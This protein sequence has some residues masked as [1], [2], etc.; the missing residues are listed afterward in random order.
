MQIGAVAVCRVKRTP[1]AASPVQMRCLQIGPLVTAE[2]V[3]QIVTVDVDH[4]GVFRRVARHGA[5]SA[6]VRQ[7]VTSIRAASL[8]VGR[9]AVDG[10]RHAPYSPPGNLGGCCWGL[11]S[12]VWNVQL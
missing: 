12:N 10:V 7:L 8:S 5:H 4:V 3:A 1:P 6:T 2:P 11:V 9:G